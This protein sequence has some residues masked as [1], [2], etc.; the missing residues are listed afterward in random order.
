MS[1]LIASARP[2]AT[3]ERSAAGR[4]EIGRLRIEIAAHDRERLRGGL[5]HPPP[6][7]E[8]GPRSRIAGLNRD[9]LGDRHP[10]DEAEILVNEGDRQRIR[11]RMGRLA[12]KQDLAGVGF[13][14]PRQDL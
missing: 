3:S 11:A 6:R 2:I 5:A 9:V 12:G 1:D 10:F 4:E 8:A 13:V 7:Y 14:D